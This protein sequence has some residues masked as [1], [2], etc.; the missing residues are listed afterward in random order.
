MCA[1]S[2]STRLLQR[3]FRRAAA[4]ADAKRPPVAVTIAIRR[5]ALILKN[6]ARAQ[7]VTG[8]SETIM[9]VTTDIVRSSTR[10]MPRRPLHG[11][12]SA[13]SVFHPARIVDERFCSLERDGQGPCTI[14]RAAP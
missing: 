5:V 14:R 10:K 2:T 4:T 12:S 6:A 13:D 3:F 9:P 1:E 11:I 8:S 7:P